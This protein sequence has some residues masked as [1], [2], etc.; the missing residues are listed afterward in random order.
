MTTIAPYRTPYE[1]R[2]ALVAAVLTADAC[3]SATAAAPVAE[4]ILRAVDHIPE[5]VR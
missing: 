3:L 1:M 2:V 5:K 4:K